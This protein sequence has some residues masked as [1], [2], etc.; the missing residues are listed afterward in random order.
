MALAL[1]AIAGVSSYVAPAAMPTQLH[2]SRTAVTMGVETELGATGPLGYWDP[3][4]LAVKSPEKFARWRAVELKHGRIAMMATTGYFVQSALRWP[5]YL[6]VSENIKF[7]DLPN[8]ILALKAI[9]PVGLAQIA[10]F[11]G[12]MEIA[13]WRYYEGPWPGSV[14]AGKAPGDVAGDYWVRYSDPVEKAHKLNVEINNGRAAM[15]GALGCLMHDHI[16]GSWI[17]PGF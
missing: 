5:G 16:S 14:P 17:P 8:G 1:S 11:I 7:R 6:S 13:T 2:A 10:L 4:G 15:M 3:L 12:L 9:P